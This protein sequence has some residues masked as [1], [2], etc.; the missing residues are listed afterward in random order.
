MIT[1]AYVECR[2]LSC[3]KSDEYRQSVIIIDFEIGNF[4][5]RLG[6]DF[7]KLGVVLK[8]RFNKIRG[9]VLLNLKIRNAP[10]FEKK[11]RISLLE[12][13]VTF[14]FVKYDLYFLKFHKIFAKIFRQFSTTFY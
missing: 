6:R 10:N 5:K 13:Y 14:V 7:V 1:V 9:A 3:V 2:Q 8:N 11:S 4:D 12:V